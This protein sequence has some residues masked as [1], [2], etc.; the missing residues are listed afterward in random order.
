[1]IYDLNNNLKKIKILVKIGI[2]KKYENKIRNY[3][4]YPYI[5]YKVLHKKERD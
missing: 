3:P 1:M 2:D 5:K 4:L